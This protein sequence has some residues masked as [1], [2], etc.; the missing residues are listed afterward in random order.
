MKQDMLDDIRNDLMD[1]PTANIVIEHNGQ[2]YATENYFHA[3]SEKGDTI[4]LIK[5]GKETRGN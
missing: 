5:T 3:M 4:I 2:R 1:M